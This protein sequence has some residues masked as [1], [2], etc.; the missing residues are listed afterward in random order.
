MVESVDG[1]YSWCSKCPPS[2]RTWAFSLRRHWFTA[3][4]TM[5]W[6]NLSHSSTRRSFN[7]EASRI[8]VWYTRSCS[9]LQ[10][11]QSTGLRSRLFGCLRGGAMKF[12]RLSLQQRNCFMSAISWSTVLLE[13]EIF[14]RSFFGCWKQVFHQQYVSIV[15]SVN[16]HSRLNEDKLHASSADTPADTITDLENV[17]H[18][19]NHLSAD[20]SAF[21]PARAYRRSFCRFTVGATVNNFSSVNQ[22]KFTRRA[23]YF[24]R[25][26]LDQTKRVNL[27]ASVS[28][29]ALFFLKHCKFSSW[30]LMLW[31]V[32]FAMPVSCA[33]C[34]TDRCMPGAS[35]WLIA[36]SLTTRTF[37]CM[38]NSVDVCQW[39]FLLSGNHV[40]IN[41][42]GVY[43][44]HWETISL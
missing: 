30:W 28:S 27:L 14:T 7:W 10:H 21:V 37:C 22:I 19:H 3:R 44:A 16:L 36:S 23:G 13:C 15:H 25:S 4:F 26:C 8:L 12:W 1:G 32:D 29:C 9:T 35:S 18:V 40:S 2:A 20:S 39:P 31:T 34:R 43:Q 24:F 11:L 38:R 5:A 42:T 6:S 17:E 33:I 41:Q